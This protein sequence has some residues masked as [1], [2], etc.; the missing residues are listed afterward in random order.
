MK[1]LRPRD[2]RRTF[3]SDLLEVGA[4]IAIVSR[5]AGHANVQTTVRCDRRPK[6]KQVV[7][8]FSNFCREKLGFANA[9]LGDVHYYQSLPLCV[10][11]AVFSINANYAST[12]NTVVRFCKYIDLQCLTQER[13]SDISSQLSITEFV[14][15][16]DKHD[17]EWM[18][19]HVYRN[20]QRT[21][22]RSGIL[23]SEA[24]MMFGKTLY[25]HKV[26]Y[27]QDVGK[28]I[29]DKSFEEAIKGIPGQGSGISLNYFY[30]LAGSDDYVKPDRML[31]RFIWSALHKSF[32]VEE[33]QALVAGACQL[34][35]EEHPYL[36]PRALDHLIWNYQRDQ[37]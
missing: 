26:D 5:M 12:E 16:H 1:N 19:E 21:S 33:S 11:D 8:K 25:E 9:A 37:G 34:L 31:E 36:T 35:R 28:V 7:R 17:S 10:I 23:K 14:A 13:F 30:M 4:D 15:L 6:N 2:L 3:V 27:I 29:G 24:V 32:S 18:A 20:R 22:T